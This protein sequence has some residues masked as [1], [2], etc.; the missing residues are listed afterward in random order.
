MD[1]DSVPKMDL[2]TVRD[3][4][5]KLGFESRFNTEQTAICV[6]ALSNNKGKLMRIHDIIQYAKDRLNKPYAEN[7]RESIRKLS[8]KRLVNHGLVILNKDDPSRPTNSGK[9]NYVLADEF[10]KILNIG[11]AARSKLISQWNK[12]HAHIPTKEEQAAH[13]IDI[14][15]PDGKKFKLSPGLHNLLVKKIVEQLIVSHVEDPEVVYLGDTRNKMLYTNDK[16]IKK[17]GIILDEHD[18]LPDVIVWSSKWK[19][20]IV[21]ES[22][23]SVGPVEE[24]RKKEIDDVINGKTGKDYD[25]VYIT[26]FLDRQTYGKFA[27]II[28]WDTFVWI[29]A[30]PGGLIRY[31]KSGID[32]I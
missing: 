9:T 29:A 7:T 24:S 16:L 23:T 20:F 11:E 2:N 18:K 21:I 6:I 5:A 28:A 22:V 31:S 14:G 12:E 15:L 19:K 10:R 8:L 1:L 4:L 17:L 25:I 27:K 13:E 30:E 32:E 26:A 3:I